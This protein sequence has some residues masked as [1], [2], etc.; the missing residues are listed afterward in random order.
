MAF[1]GELHTNRISKHQGQ[2]IVP[3]R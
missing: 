3:Q 1:Q 2:Q